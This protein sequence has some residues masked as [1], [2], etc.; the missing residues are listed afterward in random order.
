MAQSIVGTNLSTN[1]AAISR[2]PC[3]E[4]LIAWGYDADDTVTWATD[5]ED[6]SARILNIQ[7]GRELNIDSSMGVG[8]GTAA[9]LT[10]TLD[11]RDQRYSPH[12][13]SG[14]LW[15]RLTTT[16]TTPGG[17]TVDYP[18][19]FMTPV[20]V[21]AGYYDGA[22]AEYVTVFVGYIDQVDETY[23]VAGDTV[24]IKCL[25]RASK[26]VQRR[27]STAVKV[28]W[29]TDKWLNYIANGFGDMSPVTAKIDAGLFVIPYAW[30][31]DE[32]LW[33]E[34]Q[35]AAASEG[36]YA[37]FDEVGDFTFHNALWWATSTY[38]IAPNVEFTTAK[39]TEVS[40]GYDWRDVATGAIVEYQ[41]RW[42][43]GEQVLWEKKQTTVVPPGGT[44]VEAR[45]RYPSTVA[46]PPVF[47]TDWLPINAGGVIFAND[48]VTVSLE[49]QQAQRCTVTFTNNTHET[50][51]V[52]SIRIRGSA[53][54][55]GPNEEI[56]RN[57]TSPLVPENKVRVAANPYVQTKPQ[58]ELLADLLA[59]RMRYPRL[60]YRINGVK[61]LPWLQL[62]DKITVTA[63]DVLTDS[64]TA[65]ITALAFTWAPEARFAM[66]VSA[67]DSAGLYPYTSFFV[68][69]TSELGGAAVI[70]R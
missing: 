25:D 7:W 31:D 27:A 24:T 59:D 22:T 36:G 66:N 17:E 62:G 19:F 37:F 52:S 1:A 10:V 61:A 70:Y 48:E 44:T 26:L 35:Q 40:P 15:D 65:I 41:A 33:D 39:F 16:A 12:N 43:G 34:V 2:K 55:G 45:Y 20:R 4:L 8:R 57:V 18:R 46:Y 50:A 30:L 54:V 68:I 42:S 47:E 56:E 60:I 53:I 23:G 21:R 58:A 9:T 63:N 6:E 14:A 51:F 69:G 11:N 49:N 28:N 3:V 64:R 13:E 29:R 5:G 67:V 38:S 32:K